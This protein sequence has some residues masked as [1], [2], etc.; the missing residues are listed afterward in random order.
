MRGTYYKIIVPKYGIK[1]FL[2]FPLFFRQ[3]GLRNIIFII[4]AKYSLHLTPKIYFA[5]I[6]NCFT[7]L[8]SYDFIIVGAGTAGTVVANGLS[9]IP[10]VKVLLLEAGGPENAF[11]DIPGT[12]T[13]LPSSRMNWGYKTTSQKH[14]CFGKC[15]LYNYCKLFGININS[16][17]SK[18]S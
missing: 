3:H 13:Y 18:T 14:S 7:D 2:K 16:L 15:I 5:N 9:A 10:S 4:V 6:K 12:I 8:G 1:Y 17:F 11:S